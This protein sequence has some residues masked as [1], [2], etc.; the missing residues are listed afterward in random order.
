[1]E[2]FANWAQQ[3][4]GNIWNTISGL[5]QEIEAGV[6]V[7]IATAIDNKIATAI[8]AKLST[9]TMDFNTK[10]AVLKAELFAQVTAIQH[11]GGANPAVDVKLAAL[12]QKFEAKINAVTS[13]LKDAENGV[14]I[15]LSKSN[16]YNSG[17]LEGP[18]GNVPT[19]QKVRS[20]LGAESVQD[21]EDKFDAND[22]KRIA[23]ILGGAKCG[24]GLNK[25]KN[26]NGNCQYV[27]HCAG[28]EF[29]KK[30]LGNGGS[31]KW[32]GTDVLDDGSVN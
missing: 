31:F 25:G 4:I 19:K 26:W 1:M 7:K 28:F 32:F 17:I 24:R 21:I 8:D 11:G 5:R 3:Q 16:L 18:N 29:R 10:I 22:L 23:Q 27:C 12:T 20:F 13:Q 9:F 6:D 2:D 14:T 30:P 15:D